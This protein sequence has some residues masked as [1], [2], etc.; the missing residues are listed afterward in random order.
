MQYAMSVIVGRALPDVRD[1]LKPVQRR[2]LYAMHDLGLHSSKPYRKCARV[3]GEVLGKFHPH[4]DAAVYAALVRMAQDFSMRQLLVAGHGNFGSIDNDPAAAMRYT[5]C[6]LDGLS[7]DML[8]AD[9]ESDT[10]DF[11]PTFDGVQ[12][13]P[14]VLPAR[15]PNLLVNGSAGIAVGVATKI[16]PHNMSEVLGALKALVHNPNITIDE[17]MDHVPAPD[18]PTGGEILSTSGVREA[19][20]TGHGTVVMRGCAH[21]EESSRSKGKRRMNGAGAK[22]CIIIT[23]LPYK[24]SKAELVEG[25]VQ[26]VENRTLE[27]VADVRD[28]SDREGIRLVVE[29]KRGSEPQVVLNNLYKHSR[30][31]TQFPC[32]MVALVNGAPK[33]LNLKELLVHFVEFRSGVVERR[34]RYHLEQSRDRL[35]LVVGFLAAMN[36]LDRVIKTIRA[37]KDNADARKN[38][39]SAHN[40]SQAQAEGILG[41]SLRRLTSMEAEKL[42]S[43]ERDLSMTISDLE[44]LLAK[45]ERVQQEVIREASDLERKYRTKRRTTVIEDASWQLSELDIIPNTPSIL[46]Y[47]S[48]GFLKRVKPENFV[49]R[50]RGGKGVYGARMHP[51]DSMA[52]ILHVMAHDSILL[53]SRSGIV[54]CLQAYQIPVSSRTAA[55]TAITQ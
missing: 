48:R 1:G 33:E 15:F 31:M 27:G 30:L 13:E 28:E 37:S 3:V 40:F 6:R 41:M 8:L 7:S 12:E 14:T 45:P 53:F 29:V 52:E 11:L 10:V 19:Y 47:S 49:A 46:V 32:N 55:G 38:L 22:P 17:L 51:D 21:I 35:H 34:A 4:G 54:Y 36:D 50:K 43:E 18:F 20:M 24:V 39:A 5:E 26:L 2:I 42:T 44:D 23:E 9:L 25:F 16:P